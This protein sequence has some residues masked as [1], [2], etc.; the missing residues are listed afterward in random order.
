MANAKDITSANSNILIVGDAGTWKT[1][2]L[3]QIPGIHI[4]DF[5]RGMA[6]NRGLDIEYDTFKDLGIGM[7]ESEVS[8]R[9]GLY[10]WGT[11]WEHFWKKCVDINEKFNKGT[12]PAAIGLDSL[13]MMSMM[14]INKILKDTGHASAHQGTWGSHHE[15]FKT[16]FSTM[17]AWP[18]RVIAT[19]H[20]ERT[21]NDLTGQTEKLPLLAGKLA[22]MI[23]IFFDEVWYAN[24]ERKDGKLRYWLNTMVDTNLRQ[25]KSRFGLPD[26]IPTNWEDIA[27]YLSDKPGLPAMPPETF[28]AVAPESK[29]SA[30]S[31][32]SLKM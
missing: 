28:K 26:N 2:L 31:A 24:V 20:I 30:V 7:E 25:S 1:H 9:E 17:T 29:F 23:P 13:T 11:A 10:R 14:V 16:I 27:K 32:T 5:D 22:A 6:I 19:A 21:T 15:Y 8:R 4:M 3:G 12:G 18:C